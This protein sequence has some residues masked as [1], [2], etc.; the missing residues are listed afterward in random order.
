MSLHSP[1]SVL[2]TLVTLNDAV[3]TNQD[4]ENSQPQ[5]HN[6]RTLRGTNNQSNRRFPPLF[7]KA[8]TD[9]GRSGKRQLGVK[10]ILQSGIPGEDLFHFTSS[11]IQVSDSKGLFPVD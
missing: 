1:N 6:H 2:W 8:T 11:M 10:K 5:T 4:L 3:A 7:P 9:I